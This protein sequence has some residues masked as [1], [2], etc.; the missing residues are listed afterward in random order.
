MNNNGLTWSIIPKIYKIVY[1]SMRLSVEFTEASTTKSNFYC[2]KFTKISG[3]RT[4]NV[5]SYRRLL[6]Y[7]VHTFF[8]KFYS[9]S[10]K[11]YTNIININCGIQTNHSE[12][13]IVVMPFIE[14]FVL[15]CPIFDQLFFINSSRCI[16][17]KLPRLLIDM[18]V[19]N[20]DL[21]AVLFSFWW[22]S[23]QRDHIYLFQSWV[24][25]LYLDY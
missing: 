25:K 23:Y 9:H 18:P 13:K 11:Y 5:Q 22:K 2:L 6:K 17:H 10:R 4:T 15:F 14:I 8:W 21:E 7:F 19:R 24:W 3:F 20:I 16:Q 12:I 1:Q